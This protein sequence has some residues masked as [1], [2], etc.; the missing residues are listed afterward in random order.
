MMEK[1]KEK[2]K[3]KELPRLYNTTALERDLLHVLLTDKMTFARVSPMLHDYWMSDDGRK[4]VFEKLN[5]SFHTSKSLISKEMLFYETDKHYPVDI[6]KMQNESIRNEI[7]IVLKSVPAENID[8]IID[9]LDEAS[10]AD[11]L[12][13]T[14]NDSYENLQKGDIVEATKIFR[15]GYIQVITKKKAGK[16][17]ALHG[18]S[19]EFE[20]DLKRRKEHPELYTGIRTGLKRF[21]ELTGGLFKAELTIFFGLT[22]K[23]KSTVLKNIASHMR[24]NGYSIL[25]VANEENSMQ[26][27]GKYHSLENQIA[28]SKLKKGEYDP[29]EYDKWKAYN[30][31]QKIKKG[32]I[33][34]LNIPQMT[35]VT[36]IE[37]AY[38]ELKQKGI[39]IDVIIIDYMDLMAPS[40]KAYSENDEQAKVTNDCKQLS[41][42]CDVPVVS[43]TQAA[44]ASEKQEMKDKPFLTASDIYGTKRK[45][46]SAN[47][48]IGLVNK[49]ATVAATEKT[50]EERNIQKLIFCVPKNRDGPIFS[51]RQKLIANI[52]LLEEDEE[53]DEAAE[54]IQ[55][56]AEQISVDVEKVEV[57]EAV[58]AIEKEKLKT[59]A[60][61]HKIVEK[62]ELKLDP[63]KTM[64]L[65]DRLKNMQ[66]IPK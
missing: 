9:K 41:I 31:E 56:Y 34:V 6:K 33:Y 29:S 54:K 21:D 60:E 11:N 3:E 49:T 1:E 38:I 5:E 23:G 55:K 36:L 4:F 12:F 44:T 25:H 61:V 20:E 48:L 13:K 16:I 10:L 45:A 28:Y 2:K 43:A 8:F 65:L 59:D 15:D 52:G 66:K 26:V 42:D 63:P 62:V 17:I 64:S 35:D 18:E 47:T 30:D 39:V 46:H 37:K 32:D 27:Q 58:S 22:G 53:Q 57:K 14:I 7:E 24:R 50:I 40:R 51:F 19:G